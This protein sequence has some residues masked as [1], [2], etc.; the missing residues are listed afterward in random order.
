MTEQEHIH[1]PI[2]IQYRILLDDYGLLWT[3]KKKNRY[4]SDCLWT[5]ADA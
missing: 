2:H 1:N 4:K 3:K 5:N